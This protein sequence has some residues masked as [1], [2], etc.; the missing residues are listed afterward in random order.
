LQPP[1][2]ATDLPPRSLAQQ[3]DV[4][5][6]SFA[7]MQGEAAQYLQNL[8]E[9]DVPRIW[10]DIEDVLVIPFGPPHLR[11]KLVTNSQRPSRRLLIET[12]QRPGEV[13]GVSAAETRASAQRDAEH[14]GRMALAALGQ[15][16]FD[17]CP[18]DNRET[19]LQVR[20]RL[21][22]FAVDEDWWKSIG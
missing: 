8:T 18:G 15:R 4:V 11:M 5:R 7:R 21:Q 9:V 17:E 1:A 22:T 14:Q 12:D 2:H 13:L 6:Q 19:Y 16:W 3:A 20:H 10:R